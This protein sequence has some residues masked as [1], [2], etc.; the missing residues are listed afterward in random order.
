M[1]PSG[2]PEITRSG[3]SAVPERTRTQPWTETIVIGVWPLWISIVV[4][5]R[6]G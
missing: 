6:D 5:G 3:P 2:G 1:T 4:S